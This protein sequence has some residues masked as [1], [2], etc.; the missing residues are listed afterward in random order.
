MKKLRNER[1]EADVQ[2]PGSGCCCEPRSKCVT[3]KCPCHANGQPC[4]KCSCSSQRCENN[5]RISL[6]KIPPKLRIYDI[7]NEK[8]TEIQTPLSHFD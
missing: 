5:V 8:N 3:R 6:K 1:Q 4:H 2:P 7:F